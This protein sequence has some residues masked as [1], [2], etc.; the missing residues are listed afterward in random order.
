MVGINTVRRDDPELTCRL[1]DCPSPVRVVLDSDLNIPESA[2][3]VTSATEVKTVVAVSRRGLTREREEKKIRLS[4]M[5]VVVIQVNEI[6]PGRLSIQNLLSEL[7][8]QNIYSVY[9]E[10]GG[11]VITSFLNAGAVDRMIVVVAPILIGKGVHSIGDLGVKNLSE[12]MRPAKV[13]TYAQGSDF[14][15]N[16]EFQ[17][18]GLYGKGSSTLF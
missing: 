14:V 8:K 5:G 1:P 6:T 3:V 13:S 12:A 2:K 15:W 18:K 17:K 10:G 9:V 7:M 11:A 16:L 4:E